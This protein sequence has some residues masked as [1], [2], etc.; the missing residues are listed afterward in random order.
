MTTTPAAPARR[1]TLARVAAA[2]GV[3]L[4][5][6]SKV[7]NGKDD[8]APA[9]RA[10]VQR[11]LDDLAYVPVGGRRPAARPLVDLVFTALDSP[12]AVE[13][14]RGVTDSDLDV[15]VSSVA[16]AP[17]P[18]RWAR[19]LL[20][21]GRSGAIAV[22]SQLGPEDRRA[23]QRAGLPLVVID[24]VDLPDPGLPSVGATNWAGGLAATEH[25]VGLGHRRVAV[26]GGPQAHWCSRAR[27]DGYRAA[28]ERAG[29]PVDPALV[30]H[31]DFHHEGGH[32][33]ALELLA[34]PDPPT[35]IFAG[36]DEQALGVLEAARS[37]GL[38]V[39]R[40]LSVVGFDDLPVARWSAPPLTTVRQPLAE[41][42]RTAAQMLRALVERRELDSRRV[43]LATS[44]VVRSST[45]APRRTQETP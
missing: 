35:G 18:G 31:G 26:I 42:G 39:P 20:A 10:R 41:M 33:R 22:T 29:L 8:V 43:E 6:V 16:G 40:D 13:V 5:T 24:P 45:A 14:L 34:L 25:L 28:L 30:R 7:L 15:V 11:A 12:W 44:L 23:V 19:S 27:V 9:T 32:A 37:L 1:P 21:R 38:S 2:A 3:S 4:P 36:S 17:D